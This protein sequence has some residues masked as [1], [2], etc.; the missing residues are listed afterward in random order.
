MI[1]KIE[2]NFSLV[3]SIII[4][5]NRSEY[6]HQ[7]LY[8]DQFDESILDS[9]WMIGIVFFSNFRDLFSLFQDS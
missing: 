5:K 1:E 7:C 8:Y 2:D 9:W 4:V 6:I 3:V